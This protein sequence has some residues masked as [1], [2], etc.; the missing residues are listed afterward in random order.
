MNNDQ[1]EGQWKQIKGKVQA[2]WGKLTDDEIDQADGNRDV[3]EGKIQERY[4][5]SKEHAKREV[6]EFINSL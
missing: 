1:F 4:G 5:H 6:N 2:K 3:L